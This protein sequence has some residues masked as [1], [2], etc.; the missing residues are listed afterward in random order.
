MTC[1]ICSEDFEGQ[2]NKIYLSCGHDFH[3]KC[4]FTLLSHDDKKCPNC[5]AVIDY[6]VPESD[7]QRRVIKLDTDL[8]QLQHDYAVISHEYILEQ[9]LTIQMRALQATSDLQHTCELQLKEEEIINLRSEIRIKDF[10]LRT[11]NIEV[12]NLKEEKDKY[13]LELFKSRQKVREFEQNGDRFEVMRKNAEIRELKNDVRNLKNEVI[14]EQKK[15]KK[16]EMNID[17]ITTSNINHANE[18]DKLLEHLRNKI[19]T[20]ENK[21]S[22]NRYDNRRHS[23]F[24]SSTSSSARH[25]TMTRNSSNSTSGTFLS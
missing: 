4:F 17:K 16:L 18:V 9:R 25:R 11:K 19:A 5:R 6:E 13:L 20:I 1:T 12:Q 2:K 21:N 7:I 14:D 10:K 22:S 24:R 3:C 8:T 23:S 15:Y